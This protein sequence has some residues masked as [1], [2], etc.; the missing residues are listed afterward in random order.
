MILKA[1]FRAEEAEPGT[2]VSP[3]ARLLALAFA[4]E[5]AVED[6][7]FRSVAEAAR[8]LGV[9][10]ARLSQVSRRRWATVGEQVRWLIET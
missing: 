5:A 7:R 9:S 8:A 1:R 2:P 3:E 10:R 6:G 4:I